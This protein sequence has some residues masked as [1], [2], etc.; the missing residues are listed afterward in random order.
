MPLPENPDRGMIYCIENSLYFEN[1]PNCNSQIPI[2]PVESRV[3]NSTQY[4]CLD[5]G[6]RSHT[7]RRWN[8]LRRGTATGLTIGTP[9]SPYQEATSRKLNAWC[10]PLQNR[11]CR[12]PPTNAVACDHAPLALGSHLVA[13]LGT[14]DEGEDPQR[15][16]SA[17]R[18]GPSAEAPNGETSTT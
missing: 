12:T 9:Q 7:L 5:R 1:Y 11:N 14:T 3:Y 8:G 2:I 18:T 13:K 6:V 10:N 15:Q 17:D 16:G 4:L